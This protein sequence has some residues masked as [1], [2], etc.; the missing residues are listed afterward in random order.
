MF[1]G[2]LEVCLLKNDKIILLY[3]VFV[4]IGIIRAVGIIG[5][6]S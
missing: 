1:I 2:L 6:R 3:R 5:F 4:F